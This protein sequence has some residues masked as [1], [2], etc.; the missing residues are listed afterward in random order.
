[1]ELFMDL[2]SDWVGLLSL[3][4]I[5]FIICMAIYFVYMFIAKS[6]NPND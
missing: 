3:G 1:M 6:G 4:T 5:A 2:F